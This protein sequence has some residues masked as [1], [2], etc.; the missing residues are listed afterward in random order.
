MGEMKKCIFHLIAQ[1]T[2]IH[3]IRLHGSCLSLITDQKMYKLLDL[4]RN[5][6]NQIN[7]LEIWSSLVSFN[8]HSLSCINV[9]TKKF[10]QFRIFHLLLEYK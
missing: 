9:Y 2:E 10:M 4:R 5:N 8:F 6:A 7:I 3:A 1:G